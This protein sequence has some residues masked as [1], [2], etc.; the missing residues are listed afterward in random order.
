VA[1]AKEYIIKERPA[2]KQSQGK[3]QGGGQRLQHDVT[4]LCFLVPCTNSEGVKEREE[5]RENEKH[6]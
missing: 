5:E 2:A 3:T 4:V 1:V 6:C